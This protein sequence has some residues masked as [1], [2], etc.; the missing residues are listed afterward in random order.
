MSASQ[1]WLAG[2]VE[3]SPEVILMDS[4]W[5]SPAVVDSLSDRNHDW[6][7]LLQV[8]RE[9]ELYSLSLPGVNGFK[10]Q[11]PGRTTIAHVVELTLQAPYQAVE[12]SQQIHWSYTCCFSAVGL[13][14]V[15]FAVYFDNPN[16]TRPY[17]ALLTNRIDWSASR[18]LAQ[19]T[20]QYPISSLYGQKKVMKKPLSNVLRK[21]HG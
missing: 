8:D 6:I 3:P 13:G 19:W 21:A 5:L 7:G 16:K 18:I 4:R 14:R 11:K 12:V 2:S 15:R 17:V 9:I 10:A 20:Q 1:L